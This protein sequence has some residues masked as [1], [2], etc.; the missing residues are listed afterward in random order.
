MQLNNSLIAIGSSGLYGHK[1]VPLYFPEAGTDFI[2]TTFS[3]S[4]GYLGSVMLLLLLFSFDLYI[5]DILRTIKNRENK[6]TLFGIVSLFLYQQVQNI[7]MTLGLLPM[8]GI[9]LPLISYGGS[10]LISYFILIGI[11]ENIKKRTYK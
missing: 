6:Y 9:T 4:F 5:I 2:F 1:N 10:S 7:G 8:T 11:V 3:S